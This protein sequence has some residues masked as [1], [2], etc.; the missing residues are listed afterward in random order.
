MNSFGIII[1]ITKKKSFGIKNVP[2][3]INLNAGEFTILKLSALAGSRRGLLGAALKPDKY[4]VEIIKDKYDEQKNMPFDQFLKW[5]SK[6]FVAKAIK[7]KNTVNS[8][9]NFID[10]MHQYFSKKD[11]FISREMIDVVYKVLNKN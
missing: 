11:I 7:L 1:P 6:A 9:E 8:R 4:V 2:L 5:E 3:N 10:G